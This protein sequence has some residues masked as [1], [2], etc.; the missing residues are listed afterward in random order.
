ES[1]E[2]ARLS[3]TITSR[4]GSLKGRGRSNTALIKLNI[5]LFAPIPRASVRT[6]TAVNPGLLASVR[7]PYLKSCM[8]PFMF[9]LEKLGSGFLV[10]GFWF[11]VS[12]S[13]PASKSQTRNQKP[14]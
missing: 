1:L 2:D 12:G 6:A 7:H 13:D 3:H 5:A 14:Q 8:T 11:L 10:C 9:H 4:S